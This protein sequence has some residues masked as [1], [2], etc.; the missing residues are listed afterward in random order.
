MSSGS[1]MFFCE[2]NKVIQRAQETQRKAVDKA[3]AIIA[4]SIQEGGLL[5]ALG[6]GHSHALAMEVFSRAGGLC[7]VQIV[8][9]P[10]LALTAGTLRSSRIERIEGYAASILADYD[11]RA[12][13]VILVISNSGRNAVPIET[14]MYARDRDMK[15][16]ALTNVTHSLSEPSRHSSGRHLLDLAD[17]VLDNCGHHGDA[18]V[19]LPELDHL[20]GPTSTIVGAMLINAMITQTV[21][22]IQEKGGK[23]PV[24]VSSNV[25]GF[26]DNPLSLQHSRFGRDLKH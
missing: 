19:K 12:G 10:S 2:V 23:P 6:T 17:V 1:Q 7:P 5:F 16:I 13:D 14:A 20:V 8:L 9:C 26:D 25:S 22:K 3:A 11:M 21:A 18:A 15:V 24:L 4:D